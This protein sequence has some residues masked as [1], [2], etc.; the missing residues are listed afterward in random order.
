MA[1]VRG[2]V[3]KNWSQP[4]MDDMQRANTTTSRR[5]DRREVHKAH[6]GS[7]HSSPISLEHDEKIR[8]GSY[9]RLGDERMKDLPESFP[10]RRNLA[11]TAYAQ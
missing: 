2:L 9:R 8:D 6:A 11:M 7:G 1:A 3:G 10:T 4:P 5:D